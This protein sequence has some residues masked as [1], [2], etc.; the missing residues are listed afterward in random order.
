[1]STE[2]QSLT[3]CLR[4][5]DAGEVIFQQFCNFGAVLPHIRDPS[6]KNSNSLPVWFNSCPVYTGLDS[7]ET[8]SSALNLLLQMMFSAS[9]EAWHRFLEVGSSHFSYRT[10]PLGTLKPGVVS[11]HF[12]IYSCQPLPEQPSLSEVCEV[13]AEEHSINS[14]LPIKYGHSA[15]VS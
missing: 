13:C 3:C 4:S 10:C 2:E 6:T 14:V 1:M 9:E 7:G 8:S 15:F 12:W 5:R 11:R